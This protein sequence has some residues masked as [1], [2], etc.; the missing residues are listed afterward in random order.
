MNN[1]EPPLEASEDQAVPD[2]QFYEQVHQI[3]EST[4]KD[5]LNLGILE[6][7]QTVDWDRAKSL[8]ESFKP[9]PWFIWRLS[10]H[11]FSQTGKPKKVGEGMVY[12]L[13][14][15]LLAAS[16]DRVL[17]NGKPVHNTREAMRHLRSDVVAATSVI[18]SISKKFKKMDNEKIW[19][20]ILE[21]AI[22][23]SHIGFFVGQLNLEFGPGR[24]MLAGFAGRVG[25]I[26]LIASGTRL[27]AEK[28]MQLLAEGQTLRKV[29]ENIY[30]LDPLQVSA[31]TLSASGCGKDS[32]FGTVGYANYQNK[33]LTDFN[34]T[35][36]QKQWLAAFMITDAVRTARTE[37]FPE[38]IW[39][40]LGFGQESDRTDLIEVSKIIV[41]KGHGWDWMM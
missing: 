31:V 19:R 4:E 33:V 14:K 23:R 8:V 24:G 35:F 21:D 41:R 5:L 9:V 36:E 11:A 40:V 17:G 15:M 39:N 16:A 29:G 1:N 27:E 38:D 30:G 25:L 32:A 26:I 6:K 34:G 28:C 12:G 2:E 22:L 13:K 10:N 3:V 37:D 18:H 20:P 7:N